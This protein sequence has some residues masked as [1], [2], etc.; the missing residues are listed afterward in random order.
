MRN[1]N[2]DNAK[3]ILTLL[4]VLYHIQYVGEGRCSFGFMMI[5]NLGDCVVPAFA[6]ISGFLFWSTVK[7]LKDLKGK[8]KRRLYSLLLPYV[9]WNIINTLIVNLHGG[10]G[11]PS[12]F[13]L[14]IWRN[15][16]MWDSSP[17]FWY[18][19]MLMFWTALSPLLFLL[20]YKKGG[21]V[22]L[23]AI[24]GAYLLYKGDA[25]LHS[26]FIYI[27]Y[28]WS[29][30]FGYIYPDFVNKICF[31]GK[32]RK[33][34]V[35]VALMIYVAIYFSYSVETLGMGTKVWLYALRAVALLIVLVNMPFSWLGKCTNY[36]YSFWLFAIHY[37]LDGYLGSIIFRYISNVHIYQFAT[38]MVVVSI[39]LTA[40]FVVNRIMP[41]MF[42]ILTGN[43]G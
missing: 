7:D 34:V 36:K 9:L 39:G 25:V 23:F 17:H 22:V 37:W 16:V 40:G 24:S 41:S 5:K 19:F 42:K 31:V 15:I 33:T 11:E 6:I 38:W 32:K 27:L 20:Y 10:K 14:N 30:L 26:R 35:A 1:K 29:G 2:L 12:V 21:R 28:M 13:E 43:R 4:M 3:W 18:L 8:Y